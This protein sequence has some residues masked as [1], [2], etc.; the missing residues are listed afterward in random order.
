M[1]TIHELWNPRSAI[2]RSQYEQFD[3]DEIAAEDPSI[4]IR[5]PD[6][7][8][9]ILT[10]CN[11][12]VLTFCWPKALQWFFGD[13]LVE[14]TAEH[15]ELYARHHKP[16]FPDQGRHAMNPYWCRKHPEYQPKGRKKEGKVPLGVYNFGCGGV[17][18]HKT[19]K[20]TIK[21][22]SKNDK[23]PEVIRL[24]EEMMREGVMP[25]ITKTHKFVQGILDPGLLAAQM[26]VMQ[27]YDSELTRP[28]IEGDPFPL[29]AILVNPL[30]TDHRDKSDLSNGFALMTTTGSF[31]EGDL[32]CRQAALRM[33]FEAGTIT[34]V[35]GAEM[36]HS[37][38]N[39]E[40]ETRYCIVHTCGEQLRA[41]AEI[42]DKEGENRLTQSSDEMDVSEKM[43]P[44]VD[45][46]DSEQEV[47]ESNEEATDREEGDQTDE[48]YG[49]RYE[50]EDEEE[51]EAVGTAQRPIELLETPSESEEE[52]EEEAVGTEQNPIELSASPS[53]ASRKRKR[54]S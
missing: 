5:V 36:P 18:G 42:M 11:G 52:W 49:E 34:A 22:D 37:T 9:H 41:Y 44:H 2:K 46:Q 51:E 4:L 6:G 1:K 19:A 23:K 54:G 29:R 48:E 15:I 8:I 45:M 21:P 10:D 38:T 31:K 43:G 28:T 17:T 14:K 13:D 24:R 27:H 50:D 16:E 12:D 39:W 25:W 7:V 35:R 20:P 30:T 26:K 47:N 40:G 33:S 53:P 3:R 32:C